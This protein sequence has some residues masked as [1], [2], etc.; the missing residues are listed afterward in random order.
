VRCGPLVMTLSPIRIRS[1]G[2]SST[3]SAIAVLLQH[4]YAGAV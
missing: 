1:P 3:F 4:A 2:L